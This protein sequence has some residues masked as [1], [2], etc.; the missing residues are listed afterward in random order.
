[1]GRAVGFTW[2]PVRAWLTGPSCT[3]RAGAL[4]IDLIDNCDGSIEHSCCKYLPVLH[5]Y[6]SPHNDHHH[7]RGCC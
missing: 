5:V 1:M 7:N 3:N 6:C 2:T 4:T